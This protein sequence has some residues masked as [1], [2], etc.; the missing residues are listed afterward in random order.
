MFDRLLAMERENADIMEQASEIAGRDLRRHFR[1]DNPAQFAFNR[2]VQLGVF[3]VN[4]L[5]AESLR[6]RGVF[7][8]FSLGLSLGEYNHLVDI[9]ALTFSDAVRVLERR[10]E[11]YDSGPSGIMAAVFPVEPEEA[12]DAVKRTSD[13]TTVAVAMFN[14]PRQCVLSGERSAV[15]SAARL[16]E[17]ETGAVT[18]LIESRLPMHSP[19]FRCVEHLFRPVLESVE[20]GKPVKPYLPNVLGRQIDSPTKGDFVHCL[21]R[22][23]WSPVLWRQSVECAAGLDDNPIFIEVGPKSI[24]HGMLGRRW[25]AAPRRLTDAEGNLAEWTDTLALELSHGYRATSVAC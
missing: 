11:A 3:L 1:N 4:H 17:E 18:T 16:L 25:I 9:G 23:P 12:L 10:G 5:Y 2:D 20:W 8:D 21:S 24:L 7:A 19:L 6:R 22:H 14:T 13:G 15:E